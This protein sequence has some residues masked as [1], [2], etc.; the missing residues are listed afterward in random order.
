MRVYRDIQHH[1]KTFDQG[2]LNLCLTHLGQMY[3]PGDASCYMAATTARALADCKFT[4][5]IDPGDTDVAGEIARM[6]ANCASGRPIGMPAPSGSSP[7]L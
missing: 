1:G 7:M 5:L 2:A 6:R 4:P 3:V